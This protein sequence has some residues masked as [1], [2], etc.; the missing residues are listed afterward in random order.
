MDGGV[1]VGLEELVKVRHQAA[2]MTLP[3]LVRAANP[4]AGQFRSVFRGRGMEFEETRLYQPGD[5]IRNMDW[6]VTART[7]DPHSK[8]FREE[9]ERPVFL[10]VD[11]N[12]AMAFGTRVAFKSVVAARLA[13]LLGWLAAMEGDRI[14]GVVLA[15]EGPV[16]CRPAGGQR[17]LLPL[18]RAIAAKQP[19]PGNLHSLATLADGLGRLRRVARP[20]SMIIL[21]SDFSTLDAAAGRLLGLLSPHNTMLGV[22]IHDALEV[23]LPPA[24]VFSF[25]DGLRVLQLAT[26]AEKI[27]EQ[28]R[29]RFRERQMTAASLLG[30]LSVPLLTL[31]TDRPIPDFLRR[32][33]HPALL[34]RGRR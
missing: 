7:G 32:E 28:H 15:A 5:D 29:Q 10:V 31:A 20:G 21:L 33:V 2:A 9:R 6:K 22:L 18:L 13:A 12:P 3:G 34:R 30:R 16:L 26:G 19:V 23:E 1:R 14:G 17:G 24:G 4:L 25:T 27:R 11:L 8:V